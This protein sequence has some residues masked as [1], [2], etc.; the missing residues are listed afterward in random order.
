MKTL[1]LF[2]LLL[3]GL[4]FVNIAMA[5]P[6]PLTHNQELNAEVWINETTTNVNWSNNSG[7]LDGYDS[8]YFYP[9]SNPLNFITNL[10]GFT[11]DD[12]NEGLTNKYANQ[13]K[14]NHG[15]TAYLWGNHATEGYLTSESDPSFDITFDNS[16]VG[17]WDMSDYDGSI[18]YDKTGNNNLTNVNGTYVLNNGFRGKGL[19]SNESQQFFNFTTFNNIPLGNK[20]RALSVWLK[21]DEETINSYFGFSGAP[22][23]GGNGNGF[24]INWEENAISVTFGG[25]RL[26][27]PPGELELGVWYHVIAMLP[28]GANDTNDLEI[29]INGINK[30]SDLTTVGGSG[31]PH[32]L[33]TLPAGGIGGCTGQTTT[34]NGS[35]DDAMIFNRSLNSTEISELFQLGLLDHQTNISRIYASEYVSSKSGAFTY[36]N[37][38]FGRI[39]NATI[40]FLEAMNLQIYGGNLLGTLYLGSG[41]TYYLNNGGSAYFGYFQADYFDVDEGYFN[42]LSAYQSSFYSLSYYTSDPETMGWIP[43]N[44]E[45]IKAFAKDFMAYEGG[46]MDFFNNETQCYEV[47]VPSTG[48][49]YQDRCLKDM[50]VVETTTPIPTAPHEKKYR[51]D[52]LSGNL[53]TYNI[54]TNENVYS[55]TSEVQL[56]ETTGEFYKNISGTIVYFN[57]YSTGISYVKGDIFVYKGEVYEVLQSHTSQS[58]WI[59]SKTP[60]LYK[61]KVFTN[62]NEISEW[63]QPT[64]ATDCYEIGALVIFQGQVYQSLIDC[65]V[66]S[67]STYPA[68]WEAQ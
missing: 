45:R 35:I 23:G 61:I 55:L 9:Y 15:E 24:M 5:E 54:P 10:T 14:E 12:L 62:L 58:N 8:S 43:T 65:N 47:F 19:F 49:F 22:L 52:P 4:L 28:E 42:Y 37:A 34:F 31:Y 48:T 56:N 68:G 40:G 27:T 6:S 20:S 18:L 2:S 46:T 13:T 39:T 57:E 3:F 66:W 17:W 11:T 26:S 7:L 33:D 60:S 67:P 36:L 25:H 21:S 30:T 32:L 51:I 53:E 59:P 64:G 38:L 1:K 16:L 50:V 44:R 41:E 63:V 29:F